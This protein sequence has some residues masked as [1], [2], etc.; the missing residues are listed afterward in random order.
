MDRKVSVYYI[1]IM[2]KTHRTR[3]RSTKRRQHVGG[4]LG[5]FNTGTNGTGTNASSWWPFGSNTP[6]KQP[7]PEMPPPNVGANLQGMSNQVPN[8]ESVGGKRGKRKSR[9][10][11]RKSSTQKKK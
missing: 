7:N 11:R 5:W 1:F 6:T 10:S 3:S 4:F 9:S 2:A 8:S